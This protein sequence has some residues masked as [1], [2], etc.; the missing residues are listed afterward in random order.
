MMIGPDCAG[1]PSARCK[2]MAAGRGTV[3]MLKRETR[4]V[5]MKLLSAPQSTKIDVEIFDVPRWRH[6]G[7]RSLSWVG[8]RF[9]VARHVNKGCSSFIDGVKNPVVG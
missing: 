8:R 7:R 9:V 4:V 5:L 1:V 3:G 6:A 2:A